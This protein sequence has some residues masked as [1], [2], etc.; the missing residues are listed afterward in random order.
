MYTYEHLYTYQGDSLHRG[1]LVYIQKNFEYTIRIIQ[2][3]LNIHK[4]VYDLIRI[5]INVYEI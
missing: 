1:D 4:C 2:I 5:N 3:N